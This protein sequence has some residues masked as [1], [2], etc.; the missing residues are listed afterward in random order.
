VEIKAMTD[1]GASDPILDLLP[2]ERPWAFDQLPVDEQKWRAR[3]FF[4]VR[5]NTGS[6][7]FAWFQALRKDPDDDEV[8]AWVERNLS[9]DVIID[10]LT[11]LQVPEPTTPSSR[12]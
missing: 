1:L 2:E 3:V 10:G 5:I 8:R 12:P 9:D 6:L 11:S 7:P 4:G